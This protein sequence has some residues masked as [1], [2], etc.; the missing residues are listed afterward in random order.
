MKCIK[1][2]D[3]LSRQYAIKEWFLLKI[4]SL[5]KVGPAMK[6]YIGFDLV[7]H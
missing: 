6:Q 2:A 1:M 5:L 3:D 7:M 4:A